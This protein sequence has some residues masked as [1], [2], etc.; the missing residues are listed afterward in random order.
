[1]F[2]FKSLHRHMHLTSAEE[3]LMAHNHG[4]WCAQETWKWR[5]PAPWRPLIRPFACIQCQPPRPSTAATR[6]PEFERCGTVLEETWWIP[7]PDLST[8]CYGYNYHNLTDNSSY[9]S[10]S[11]F[12]ERLQRKSLNKNVDAPTRLLSRVKIRKWWT[13]GGTLISEHAGDLSTWTMMEWM[14]SRV[15]LWWTNMAIENCHL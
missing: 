4:P 13:W 2:H 5:R 9:N 15:T 12:F 1:M 10:N 8:T 11:R 7:I 14:S 3:F 6:L